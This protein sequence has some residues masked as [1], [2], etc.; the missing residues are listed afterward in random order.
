M[1]D[2]L[3]LNADGQPLGLLPVSTKPWNRVIEDIWTNKVQV[4]HTYE[5]WVVRSPSTTIHVPSVVVLNKFSKPKRACRFTKFNLCLRD[6]FTCQY[7]GEIFPESLLTYDHVH[8]HSMGGPKTWENI[9]MACQPCNGAR[10]NNTKIKPKK[11]PYR[12]SY[13][14][15]V[16]KRKQYPL[17]VPHETWTYYV[18]WSP[19]LIKIGAR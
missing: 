10:G 1:G 8:P 12:P 6:A 2:T 16:A 9:A 4:L 14:E 5:D 3:I 18:D 19:N 17:N 15:L 7:C 13:W 11:M